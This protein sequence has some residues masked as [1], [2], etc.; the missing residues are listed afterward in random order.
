MMLSGFKKH[1]IIA[2]LL[3]FSLLFIANCKPREADFVDNVGTP[4]FSIS[5]AV[6]GT[7]FQWLAGVNGYYMFSRFSYSATDTL[8][9]LEAELKPTNCTTCPNSMLISFN[10]VETAPAATTPVDIS[11]IAAKDTFLYV[12]DSITT[13]P[14]VQYHFDFVVEDSGY[15]TPSYNWTFG[16]GNGS[17]VKNPHHFY[18]DTITRNV[19]VTVT[20]G[21]TFCSKTTC[22]AVKPQPAGDTCLP[23]FDYITFGDTTVQFVNNSS[24]GA[25]SY[26]W[27]F[28]LSGPTS[29]LQNPSFFYGKKG[30]YKVCLTAT[31]GAC[32]Q[33]ICKTIYLNDTAFNCAAAFKYGNISS[34]V[35]FNTPDKKGKVTI[36]YTDENGVVYRSNI[37]SQTANSIFRVLSQKAYDPNER[38]EK[39]RQMNV[40]FKCRVFNSIGG[41]KDIDV[42]NATIAIA[43]P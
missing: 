26:F 39:T 17:T 7:P 2:A 21:T 1:S 37:G 11:K 42:S 13:V 29:N 15:I 22:N 14:T 34:A 25:V 24:Q 38:G 27:D 35:V 9:K 31:K 12:N 20:D 3:A 8:Q 19:C 18:T 23:D 28:G 10:N 30:N 33:T 43:Y 40:V 6:N 5:G 41:F 36:V 32:S 16:D 4:V